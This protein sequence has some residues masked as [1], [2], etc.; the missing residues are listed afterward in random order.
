MGTGAGAVIFMLIIG[1]TIDD[2]TMQYY[3]G[4]LSDCFLET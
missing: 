3:T 4:R 2:L 1:I